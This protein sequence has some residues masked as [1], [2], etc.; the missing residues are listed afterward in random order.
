M[1]TEHDL[2]RH[3][4]MMK[5]LLELVRNR[6][7]MLG[8]IG[9]GKDQS[10]KPVFEESSGRKL[11]APSHW[12]CAMTDIGRRRSNNEDGYFLSKDCRLWIVADGIGGHAAGEI[13]SAL[14]LQT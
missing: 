5:L 8:D 12:L 14:T 11:S 2:T 1:I 10:W 3:S 7:R 13:A 6:L 9:S 4:T